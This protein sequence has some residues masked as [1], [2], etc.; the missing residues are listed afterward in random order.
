MHI[1]NDYFVFYDYFVV[2][3]INGVYKKTCFTGLFTKHETLMKT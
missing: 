2:V 3:M 1:Y